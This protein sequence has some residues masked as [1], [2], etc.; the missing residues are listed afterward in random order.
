[1]QETVDKKVRDIVVCLER[2]R[3]LK[4]EPVISDIIYIFPTMLS[5][6]YKDLCN[7][8]IQNTLY[9]FYQQSCGPRVARVVK[10]IE[11]GMPN[12][13]DIKRLDILKNQTSL[14]IQRTSIF[15][16]IFPLNFTTAA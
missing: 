1:M 2:I 11:A 15:I 12:T 10:K 7:L 14:L 8:E 3:I 13:S 4:K 9:D 16:S 6:P 5:D